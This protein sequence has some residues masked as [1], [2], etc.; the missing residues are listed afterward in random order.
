MQ[1]DALKVDIP[2]VVIPHPLG[3]LPAALVDDRVGV[4]VG[5]LTQALQG[6]T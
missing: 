3:G 6:E 2:M 1:A 4:A 5:Q